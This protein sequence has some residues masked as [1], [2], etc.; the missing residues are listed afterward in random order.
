MPVEQHAELVDSVSDFVNI[1]EAHTVPAVPPRCRRRRKLFAASTTA[2]FTGAHLT[3]AHDHR[4][5]GGMLFNVNAVGH[6]TRAAHDAGRF[7]SSFPN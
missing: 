3:R 5:P 6:H 1:D 2:F 7:Q 4:V